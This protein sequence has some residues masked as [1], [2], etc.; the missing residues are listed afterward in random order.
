MNGIVRR[1]L[2]KRSSLKN[3]T[4][5]DLDDI[6]EELNDRPRKILDYQTPKEVLLFEMKK[7]T[8]CCT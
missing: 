5:Q 2:P 3:V 6:A 1:Y 4:Q 7:L 8:N